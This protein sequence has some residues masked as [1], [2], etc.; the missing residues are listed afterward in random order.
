MAD[1]ISAVGVAL[2]GAIEAL[3]RAIEYRRGPMLV[4][5]PALVG[6][7]EWEIADAHGAV[8]RLESRD[9][10][11]PAARLVLGGRISDPQRGDII[12]ETAADGT[13]LL[14][15]VLSPADGPP[16]RWADPGR[17]VARVHTKAMGEEKP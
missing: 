7:T 9:Y 16:W 3:G 12:A 11:V 5:L 1:P 15:E 17:Q 10:L 14:Y 4:T 2:A 8:L 13:R 6:R